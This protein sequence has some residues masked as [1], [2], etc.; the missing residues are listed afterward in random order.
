MMIQKTELTGPSDEGLTAN[1]IRFSHLLRENGIPTSLS[2]VLDAIRGVELI[3]ISNP[4]LFHDLLR[5]NFV[6]RKED[7]HL[8]SN[9]FLRFWFAEDQT[10]L[11]ILCEQSGDEE[12]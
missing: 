5:L 12:S 3:G 8:F 11:K 7:I 9:L 2:S 1:I 6:H 10:G 4:D